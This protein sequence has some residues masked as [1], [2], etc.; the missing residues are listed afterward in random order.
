MG[1]IGNYITVTAEL[2]QA[3]R[4]EEISLHGIEPKL[5]IDKAWQ[6]LHYTLSGGGTEGDSALGAVV[7]MNGQHYA[8]H[9]SDA[10]VFVLEPEQVKETAAALEGIEESYVRERYQFR[11][12]LDE[13]V[14]PLVDDDEPEEFFDYMYTYFTAM[15]EFYR[16]ASADQAYVVFYIS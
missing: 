4:D 2:L 11:Q 10:E 8:G 13:G 9:Y 5:D 3:I 16:T 15:K 1:M 14:Y 7:P 6:A 12:M